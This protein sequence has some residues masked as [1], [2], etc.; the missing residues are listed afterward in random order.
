MSYL[1][2]H[3]ENVDCDEQGNV[4]RDGVVVKPFKSNGYR[5]II[6]HDKSG[7]A[8]AYGVHN[9][10]AMKYLNYFDGC[11]VHHKDRNRH[12]NNLR[13]LEVSTRKEHC[14]KHVYEDKK[15]LTACIGRTPWNKG[16]KMS[17]EFCEKCRVS[18]LERC[19]RERGE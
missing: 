2:D 10:V 12:N 6:L 4:Y 1:S 13:N 14:R 11:V 16:K 7:K 19:K 3:F 8:R 17:K 15:F 18:A 9:I 5:Q